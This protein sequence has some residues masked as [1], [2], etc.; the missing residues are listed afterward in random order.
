MHT[1]SLRRVWL[2]TQVGLTV[3]VCAITVFAQAR[4]KTRVY[5]TGFSSPV[6]FVQDPLDRSVQFVVEQGGRIRTIRS[7]IVLANDFL[8]L[9][10]AIA[11]G[12]ERGL[13]GL[14]FPPDAQSGRFFVNFTNQ[15]GHTVVAR[16]KRTSDPLIAD[17][18]SRFDLRWGGPTGTA[19]IAQPFSNHNGG[20]LAFGPDGYLYIGLGDGGSGDDPDNRAQ[21]P[22]ELLGKML[23]IDVNVSDSHATG[24]QI[25]S[26]NPFAS[27]GPVTA[28]GEIWAFGLRNP[29]RYSFDD[30]TKG[31]TGALVIADVGQGS[32]EEIDYEPANRG[33]RNYGWRVREGAHSHITSPPAAYQPLTDPI[34]EYGHGVGQ[35]ITGGFV[36]RGN[37]LGSAYQ[38]RYFFADYVQGRVWSLAITTNGQGEGTASGLIDHTSDLGGTNVLGNISSFGVD[39][40]GEL[41]IVS[42]SRGL[43]LGVT[44][45]LPVPTAPTNFRVI[46]P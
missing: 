37:A 23:R 9:R 29:W 19:Y 46:Q 21:N 16:F 11:S 26:S 24:Y 17:P 32:Y 4:L 39:A 10:N 38:G 20:N 8:D 43:I 25:P 41:Y 14:A 6:A 22:S 18:N 13:L 40:D 42:Y 7:G 34:Y 3:L 15:A 45:S 12:G 31:G 36:Y 44:G 2:M 28:R 1:R 30:P 35:S 5:A 33:G 27:G